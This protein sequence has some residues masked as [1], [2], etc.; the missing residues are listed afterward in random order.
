MARRMAR[1]ILRAVMRSKTGSFVLDR[2]NSARYEACGVLA[3]STLTQ[4]GMGPHR[5]LD[6]PNDARVTTPVEHGQCAEIVVE[7]HQHTSLG[8][9]TR[10]DRVIARIAKPLA[11]PGDVVTERAQLL[12]GAGRHTRIEEKL[13]YAS[14]VAAT[15]SRR[16]RDA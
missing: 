5:L 1:G 10:K 6:D 12:N 11:N 13:H 7:S 16:V 2:D 15:F 8:T 14:I 9:S 3:E 4:G